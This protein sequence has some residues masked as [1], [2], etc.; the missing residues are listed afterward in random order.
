MVHTKLWDHKV[1]YHCKEREVSGR[2]KTYKLDNQKIKLN[3]TNYQLHHH[4]GKI[5]G[6]ALY[7]NIKGLC[8]LATPTP[9]CTYKQ[10]NR[11]TSPVRASPIRNIN[12]LHKR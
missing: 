5:L 9:M 7:S 12:I 10:T 6:K 11:T 4:L 1:G 2:S 8:P 3:I